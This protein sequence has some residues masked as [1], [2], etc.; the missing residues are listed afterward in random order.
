MRLEMLPGKQPIP[1]RTGVAD[2]ETPDLKS[3][4]CAAL[5]KAAQPNRT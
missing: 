3:V 4:A 1:G 5:H 2:R